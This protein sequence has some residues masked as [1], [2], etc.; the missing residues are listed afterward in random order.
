M[1]N[2]SAAR[3]PPPARCPPMLEAGVHVVISANRRGR[4]IAR[5][6]ADWSDIPVRN[7]LM[8]Y[9]FITQAVSRQRTQNSRAV[10]DR[11]QLSMKVKDVAMKRHRRTSSESRAAEAQRLRSWTAIST[12]SN[13]LR[14]SQP[15]A[16][17]GFEPGGAVRRLRQFEPR[18]SN[19]SPSDA[20][21]ITRSTR[22]AAIPVRAPRCSKTEQSD[23][24]QHRCASWWQ[25][26][27]VPR[28]PSGRIVDATA[29]HGV[30][31]PPSHRHRFVG[32]SSQMERRWGGSYTSG[33][34][35][36]DSGRSPTAT[37][38]SAAAGNGLAMS[39]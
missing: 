35:R 24:K 19:S 22:R 8:Q 31:Q 38:A 34:C 1:T 7:I 5:D 23:H 4:G 33:G 30:V 9:I 26:R 20:C 16:S 10:A 18:G 27:M 29:E 39:F 14:R 3:I 37:E 15:A 11:R 17:P 2:G 36:E 12:S 6:A 28:H 32:L 25:Q 21:S 13:T